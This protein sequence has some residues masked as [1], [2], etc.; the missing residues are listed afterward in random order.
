MHGTSL[1]SSL[2]LILL[3]IMGGFGV[4]GG[5]LLA[6]VLPALADP[7]HVSSEKVG[8]V[9]G[10]Y[11]AAAALGLPCIGFYI[12]QGYT[13]AVGGVCLFLIG[14]F[15]VLCPIA[16]SF[17]VL[18]LFRFIQG[19][20]IAGLIPLS[21]TY[22]GNWYGG[23]AR[24]AHMG[25]LSGTIALFGVVSPLVGGL[26][27]DFHWRAPFFV[28]LLPLLHAPL[29]L[30]FVSHG[31]SSDKKEK[32]DTSFLLYGRSFLKSSI[33]PGVPSVLFFSF[34]TFFLLYAF[35]VFVPLYVVQVYDEGARF[36]GLLLGVN[37]VCAALV[38]TRAVFFSHRLGTSRTLLCGYILVALALFGFVNAPSTGGVVLFSLLFGCGFGLIQ[39]LIFSR[40]VSVAT[41]VSQGSV[42]ALFNI[43]KYTGMTFAP[44]FL[45]SIQRIVSL[46]ASFFTAAMVALIGAGA[47]LWFRRG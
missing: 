39:P 21:M 29:F 44:L 34:L 7:F 32:N 16:P 25:Y 6:P 20:G 23:E 37:G 42:V 17:P 40:A 27:A 35:V 43:C 31:D 28:Y 10:V 9:L 26:A 8:L 46:H 22:I 24:L 15:G 5:S 19:F 13:R 3:L 36:S 12:D 38:S 45:G 4:M 41:P 11:T 1:R 18:L 33:L 2:S 47:S 14:F 30:L